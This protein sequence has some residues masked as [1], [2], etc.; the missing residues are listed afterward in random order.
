MLAIRQSVADVLQA[1]GADP[2]RPDPRFFIF[3]PNAAG[4]PRWRANLPALAR[5]RLQAAGLSQISGG[6]W[7]TYSQDSR[8]FSSRRVPRGGRMVAAISLR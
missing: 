7:C 6:A 2:A 4:E 3:R 5:L 1:F 8:F